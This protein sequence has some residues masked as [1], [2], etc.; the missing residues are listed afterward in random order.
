MANGVGRGLLLAVLGVLAAAAVG[1]AAVTAVLSAEP[2]ITFSAS[3]TQRSVIRGQAANYVITITRNN[4]FQGPFRIAVNGLPPYAKSHLVF[5]QPSLNQATLTVSTGSLTP[6]GL[7][8]LGVLGITKKYT[9]GIVLTLRVRKPVVPVPFGI[10]GRVTALTPGV[11]G[12]LDLTLRNPNPSGIMITRLRVSVA[13]LTAPRA[14]PALP[15]TLRDFSTR[16]YSGAYPISVP[17]RATLK[18]S[19]LGIAP[20]EQPRETLVARR[21]NQDGCR[22]ATLSLAYSGTAVGP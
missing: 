2:P 15:C 4:G 11:P 9:A 5:N 14:T 20:A 8:D 7:Y 1:A 10:S 12:T 16:Q 17:A 19:Q 22:R 3:P 6:L 18:L 21:V 13:K